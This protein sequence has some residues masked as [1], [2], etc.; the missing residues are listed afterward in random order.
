VNTIARR[1]VVAGLGD[2]P[3]CLPLRRRKLPLCPIGARVPAP[4][5][6][7]VRS[8]SSAPEPAGESASANGREQCSGESSAAARSP[9]VSPDMPRS[10]RGARPSR[11]QRAVNGSK[12]G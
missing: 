6:P 10:R 1:H 8:P 7:V 4:A 5:T 11:W 2:G 9:S 3:R 12:H